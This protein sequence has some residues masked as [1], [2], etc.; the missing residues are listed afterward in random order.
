MGLWGTIV[1]QIK[2]PQMEID[3]FWRKQQTPMS[4]PKSY[5]A[6]STDCNAKGSCLPA[7]RNC[8]SHFYKPQMLNRKIILFTAY[9]AEKELDCSNLYLLILC[10]FP[11][12]WTHLFV[13]I[14]Y[15]K[16]ETLGFY[17]DSETQNCLEPLKILDL[18]F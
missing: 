12:E 4:R 3:V 13:D 15:C 6:C 7:L 14:I 8:T 1:I 18:D 9:P 10:V 11:L 17:R 2:P 16:Y 5:S